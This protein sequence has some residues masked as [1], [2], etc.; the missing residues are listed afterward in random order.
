MYVDIPAHLQACTF[1]QGQQS[2]CAARGP[3]KFCMSMLKVGAIFTV[4]ALSL[5]SSGGFGN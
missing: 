2:K 4:A 5:V 3:L 1:M